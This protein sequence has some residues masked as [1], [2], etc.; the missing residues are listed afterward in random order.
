MDGHAVLRLS[1][2]DLS[3]NLLLS[4][5]ASLSAVESMIV[6]Y[7]S[8]VRLSLLLYWCRW[9][10]DGGLVVEAL[11]QILVAQSKEELFFD[12]IGG[13]IDNANAAEIGG[14]YV[15]PPS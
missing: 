1:D 8:M 11:F 6:F 9:E 7:P 12:E 13:L 15:L 5:P 14:L 3:Q 2:G 4:D 10:L